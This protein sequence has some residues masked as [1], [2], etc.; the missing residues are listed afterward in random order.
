MTMLARTEP[1]TGKHRKDGAHP[2][3]APVPAGQHVTQPA[4]AASPATVLWFL[5]GPLFRLARR[6]D[7]AP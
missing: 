3:S 4:T 2:G 5:A 6:M 7:G 1:R